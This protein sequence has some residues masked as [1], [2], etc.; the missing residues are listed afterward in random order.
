MFQGIV[1]YNSNTTIMM[2]AVFGLVCLILI[3]I[4]VNFMTTKTKNESG[5][6][7]D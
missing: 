6:E 3:G 5:N 2:V 4:L 1:L 7:E